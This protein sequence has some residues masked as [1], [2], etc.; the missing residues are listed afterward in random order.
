MAPLSAHSLEI[1]SPIATIGSASTDGSPSASVFE[2]SVQSSALAT[3]LTTT[4]DF[5]LSLTL[6]PQA[7][8][9]TK[10]AV[11]R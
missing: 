6:R 7:S 10:T 9:L 5:S 3:G 11:F 1:A 2:L 4:T 8:D